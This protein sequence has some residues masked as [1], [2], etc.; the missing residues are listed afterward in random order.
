MPRVNQS[1]RYVKFKFDGFLPVDLAIQAHMTG[2]STK[3][4]EVGTNM[5]PL[6]TYEKAYDRLSIGLEE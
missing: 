5:E 3:V 6:T 2:L 4:N 1:R